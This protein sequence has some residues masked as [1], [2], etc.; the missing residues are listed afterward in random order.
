VAE[1]FATALDLP[2]TRIEWQEPSSEDW[3]WEGLLEE[4]QIARAAGHTPTQR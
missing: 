2:L 3:T 4:I 1:N